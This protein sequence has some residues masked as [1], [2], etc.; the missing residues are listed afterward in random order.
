MTHLKNLKQFSFLIILF[1]FAYFFVDEVQS[2]R[3][4]INKSRLY[5]IRRYN[6]RFRRQNNNSEVYGSPVAPILNES[7]TT[8]ATTI[9]IDIDSEEENKYDAP[10]VKEILDPQI[11]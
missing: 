3:N 2:A 11:K 9:P 10:E 5:K 6:P 4:L 7:K 1:L 8:I